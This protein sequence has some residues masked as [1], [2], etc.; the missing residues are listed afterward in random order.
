[1][2][3]GNTK[4]LKDYAHFQII[5]VTLSFKLKL[6]EK[7]SFV[8]KQLA[9]KFNSKILSQMICFQ[10]FQALKNPQNSHYKNPKFSK[11]H[12]FIKPSFNSS[13]KKIQKFI[14][15]QEDQQGF[16]PQKCFK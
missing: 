8:M 13:S 12:E 4:E 11:K 9:K 14:K 16:F 2:P 15:T 7:I 10:R 6:F 3:I 5:R 1:M